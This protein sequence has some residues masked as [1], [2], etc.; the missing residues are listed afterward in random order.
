MYL[1]NIKKTTTDS[2]DYYKKS[3][4]KTQQQEFLEE[5]LEKD[6]IQSAQIIDLACG[7]GTLSYHLNHLFPT[8]NF[9]LVEYNDSALAIAKELNSGSNF[10]F[11]NGDIYNLSSIK[12]N[13][14]DYCFCWQALSW[15]DGDA[16]KALDEMLRI[17][18]KGGKVYLSSLFNL[19]Y[20]VDLKVQVYDRTR[21]L[22]ENS[23]YN[24]N[25][26]SKLTV[27]KWLD[28]KVDNYMLHKFTPKSPIMYEG[29]GVGTQTV[30]LKSNELLQ[31]SGGL[32]L[33]WAILEIKK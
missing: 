4:F 1:D 12:D 5:L 7:G 28:K 31:I 17:V 29:K 2:Q 13:S 3:V 16:S 25:T 15:L 11:M 14:Y 10:N 20:D 9:T 8:C 18:K 32:L 30:E 22:D 26:F 6:T 19:D 23:F 24:Y 27:S 21:G 33:N